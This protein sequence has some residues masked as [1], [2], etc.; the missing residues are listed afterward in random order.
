MRVALVHDD[1]FQWGG[2]ERV[3]LAISEIFPDAPIYTSVFD[4]TNSLLWRNFGTK[5]VVTSFMQKIPYWRSM[6]KMLLPLYPIAF[7][8]FDF[9]QF[10]LVI[11]HTTRFAKSVITKPETKHICYIHTP[12]R[13]LWGFS[14]EK[15]PKILEPYLSK[16]RIYDEV[17][18]NRVD[19]FF[20]GSKN[21]Q[22]RVEKI[23]MKKSVL[24]QPFV[25]TQAEKYKSY[26]GD[27]YLIIARLNTYKRV[28]VAVSAFNKLGYK[29][30]IVG[31]GP[32][33]N[34]LRSKANSNIEFLEFVSEDLLNRLLSGCKALIIT[35]EEDFGLVSLE[36]Q[37]FGK[38]VI[39]Y[40]NGGVL[41]TVL[42]NKTGMFFR[43]QNVTSLANAVEKSHKIAFNSQDC[44]ANANNFSKE[45]FKK[46]F[47]EEV[48]NVL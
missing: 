41:E 48:E 7:E 45:K 47:L 26:D 3:L 42:E 36:A 32:E 14:G 30:K 9:S 38:P 12:P 1:L 8:Q 40:G 16:L 27:Y 22:K 34:S 29:L 33:L 13:F 23:Y 35:G 46:K 17:S 19:V 21:C 44:I 31:K 20:A 18:A 4:H 24:M 10:D 2:A 39:A 25:E 37:S 28:D 43:E 11:S 15:V 5:K 6:Y